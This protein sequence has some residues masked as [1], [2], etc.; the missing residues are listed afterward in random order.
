M[1]WNLHDYYTD[2][3]EFT[4]KYSFKCELIEKTMS[5]SNHSKSHMRKKLA[6]KIDKEF[7][8]LVQKHSW[9]SMKGKAKSFISIPFLLLKF[10]LPEVIACI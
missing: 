4:A 8:K 9:R 5:E 1:N 3:I 2:L 10:N 6:L 7:E